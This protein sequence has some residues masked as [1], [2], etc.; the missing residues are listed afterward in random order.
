MYAC[1]V[2]SKPRLAAMSAAL[3]EK[4]LDEAVGTA[5]DEEDSLPPTQEEGNNPDLALRDRKEE[6]KKAREIRLA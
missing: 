5:L 6:A 3:A 1:T 2:G 4:A